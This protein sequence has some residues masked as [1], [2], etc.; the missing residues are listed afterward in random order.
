MVG[1]KSLVNFVPA[2]A[3]HFCLNLPE[4]FSQPGAHVLSQ[5]CKL[6]EDH[7][8]IQDGLSAQKLWNSNMMGSHML[9]KW[10]TIYEPGT[11]EAGDQQ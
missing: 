2:L 6:Q 8:S 10:M 1:L 4:K 9:L 3:Y 11:V 5:P 7:D